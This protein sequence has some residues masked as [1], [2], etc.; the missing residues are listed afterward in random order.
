MI[1]WAGCARRRRLGGG[2]ATATSHFAAA[3]GA[4][5]PRLREMYRF[6]AAMPPKTYTFFRFQGF[7]LDFAVA[8]R[9]ESAAQTSGQAHHTFEQRRTFACSFT[10]TTIAY[11]RYTRYGLQSP[12]D[13]WLA[14]RWE[15]WREC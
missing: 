8:L 10:A 13:V 1:P 3:C 4:A 14:L 11:G 6:L 2:R 15:Y 9:V 7:A 5:Q 12:V